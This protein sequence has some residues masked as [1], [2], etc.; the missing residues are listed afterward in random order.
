MVYTSAFECLISVKY[1]LTVCVHADV[2]GRSAAMGELA[3]RPA[4]AERRPTALPPGAGHTSALPQ[5]TR[6]GTLAHS[7][8]LLV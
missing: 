1:Y 2:G 4:V 3:W 7:L 5:S 6:W 8:S